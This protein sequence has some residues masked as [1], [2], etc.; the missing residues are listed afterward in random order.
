MCRI[1]LRVHVLTVTS[2]D[3]GGGGGVTGRK[4]PQF[5]TAFQHLLA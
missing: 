3:G 1:T 4:A 2:E 5:E